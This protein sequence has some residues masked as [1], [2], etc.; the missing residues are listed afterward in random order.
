MNDRNTAAALDQH[1][2]VCEERYR[3]MNQRFDGVEGRLDRLE[4]LVWL[5]IF[6]ALAS[7]A[8]AVVFVAE[9]MLK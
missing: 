2:R 4:K 8:A 6:A 7:P 3:R 1:E 9:Y 5:A